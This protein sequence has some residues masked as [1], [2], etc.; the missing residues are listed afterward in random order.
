MILDLQIARSVIYMLSAIMA[1]YGI[2]RLTLSAAVFFRHAA[3]GFDD[4]HKRAMTAFESTSESGHR[5]ASASERLAIATEASSKILPL[6]ERIEEDRREVGMTLRVISR[7]VNE[8]LER[9]REVP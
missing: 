9:D 7:K 8:L 2:L 5:I 6:L 3:Q 1:V 4:W